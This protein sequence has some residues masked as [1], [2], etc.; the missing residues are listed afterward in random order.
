MDENVFQAIVEVEREVRKQLAAEQEESE[1][2][3]ER[4]RREVEEKVAQEELRLQ[5]ELA[6]MLEDIREAELRP[7]AR[8][9]V[10]EAT[11]WAERLGRLEGARLWDLVQ[12]ELTRIV[13]EKKP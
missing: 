6:R 4:Q 1:Q 11:A 10:N 8:V 5:A 7:K 13:P 12:R 2:Q 9:V 3:L